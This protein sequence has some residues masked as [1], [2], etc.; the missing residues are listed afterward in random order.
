MSAGD[1][2][3]LLS[4]RHA[5]EVAGGRF[6]SA[7][8]WS[9]FGEI[10]RMCHP[11]IQMLRSSPSLSGGWQLQFCELRHEGGIVPQPSCRLV[12]VNTFHIPI[13]RVPSEVKALSPFC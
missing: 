9:T 5:T 11:V 7:V 2:N 6:S 10:L 8:G 12:G 3:V 4:L 1:V 13:L